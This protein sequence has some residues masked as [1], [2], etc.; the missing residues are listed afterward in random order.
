[1][2]ICPSC[3]EEIPNNNKSRRLEISFIIIGIAIWSL[4]LWWSDDNAKL[5]YW[6]SWFPKNCRA[7]IKTNIDGYNNWEYNA[8]EILDSI[9]RNCGESGYSRKK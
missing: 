9:N 4:F 6:D 3:W 2:K 7:I 5:K 1:M 8:D